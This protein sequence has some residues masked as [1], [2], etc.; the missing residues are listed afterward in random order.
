MRASVWHGRER[1][2]LFLFVLLLHSL[3]FCQA[4]AISQEDAIRET[5]IRYEMEG[6]I[7]GSNQNARL[8]KTAIEKAVAKE[9]NFKVF[10]VSINGKDPTEAFVDRLRNLPRIIKK[11]SCSGVDEQRDVVDKATGERGI[12]FR[13]DKIRWRNRESVELDGG[14]VC[15]GLCGIEATFKLRRSQGKWTITGR[16]LHRIS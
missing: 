3:C 14:Y 2:A 10:F 9:M 5:V 4:A 6:W 11:L 16:T 15:G 8:A 13:A 7:Q 1:G 12:I